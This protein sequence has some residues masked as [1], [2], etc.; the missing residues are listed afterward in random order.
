MCLYESVSVCG[1]GGG[2]EWREGD[3]CEQASLPEG[4]WQR[5]WPLG[6]AEPLDLALLG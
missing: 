4:V 5:T 2:G 6:R 1:G 3:R